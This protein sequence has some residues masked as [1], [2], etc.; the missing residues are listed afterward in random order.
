MVSIRFDWLQCRKTCNG[1]WVGGRCYW[2]CF[3]WLEFSLVNALKW[4]SM[5]VVY[6]NWIELFSVKTYSHL[7][8]HVKIDWTMCC[9]MRNYS[10]IQSW[11]HETTQAI[12]T[13][14]DNE[15]EMLRVKFIIVN[16][17]W[18]WRNVTAEHKFETSVRASNVREAEEKTCRTASFEWCM[19]S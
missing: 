6:L 4:R 9:A 12:K 7:I 16:R 17:G 11:C 19:P 3:R 5:N 15:C 18:R 8:S 13:Q 2:H 14:L 10:P 1:L